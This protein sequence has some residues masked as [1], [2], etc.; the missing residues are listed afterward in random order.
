M[1]GTRGVATGQL[2]R[3]T[4]G[5]CRLISLP[6][7][8][9]VAADSIG[10]R[11]FFFCAPPSLQQPALFL[12]ANRS[13]D[14][15]KA[16]IFRLNRPNIWNEPFKCERCTQLE[17]SGRHVDLMNGDECGIANGCL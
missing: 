14:G 15:V 8:D 4:L 9:L 17:S 2:V 12:P 10:R 16:L 7:T 11:F 13:K 1:G 6:A 5:P 3:A